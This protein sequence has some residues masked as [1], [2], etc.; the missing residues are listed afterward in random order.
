MIILL[1]KEPQIFG[2]LISV[3]AGEQKEIKSYGSSFDEKTQTYTLK[4]Y[5]NPIIF[6][7]PYR[8]KSLN[9]Y[10]FQALYLI[11]NPS[12]NELEEALSRIE[13][14]V[15]EK[16]FLPFNL[17]KKSQ[18]F[19]LIKP[20]FAQSCSGQRSCY[21]NV[22][23]ISCDN[24]QG[25][26]CAGLPCNNRCP[27]GVGKCICTTQCTQS[28]TKPCYLNAQKTGCVADGCG[29]AT[30]DEE[31][32]CTYYPPA[33]TSTPT[34][35]PPPTATPP[36]ACSLETPT[37][38]VTNIT[39]NSAKLL[40][41]Q[42][43]NASSYYLRY[44]PA[45][46]TAGS[47]VN[48]TGNKEGGTYYLNAANLN[49]CTTYNYQGKVSNP[50]CNPP[51]KESVV[52]TFTTTCP[53]STPTPTFTPTPTP[54]PSLSPPTLKS[55]PDGSSFYLG[56]YVTLEVNPITNYQCGPGQVQYRIPFI[57]PAGVTYLGAWSTST[58]RNTGPY[59]NLGTAYWWAEARFVDSNG[60]V[61][62]TS[63]ES[64]R[65]QFYIISPTSTPP[66]TNTPT[67][68]FTPT[69]TP[70]CDVAQPLSYTA[71][72]VSNTNVDLI[73]WDNATDES[74]F[75]IERR[76]GSSEANLGSW[77]FWTTRGPFTSSDPSQRGWVGN[78]D[79]TDAPDTQ[80]Y[81]WRIRSQ[82]NNP[83]NCYSN[84][85]YSNTICPTPTSTPT[86]TP[87]P[88]PICVCGDVWN[89][90]GCGGCDCPSYQRC[91]Y[92]YCYYT[93]WDG[94]KDGECDFRV[95]CIDDEV[96]QGK[97]W[98]QTKE[99]DIHAQQEIFS[100]LPEGVNFSLRG[101]KDPFGNLGFPGVVS[102]GKEAYF[103][104]GEVSDLGWLA[105]TYFPKSPFDYE[106]FYRTLESPSYLV[107]EDGK[108]SLPEG[109]EDL[110]LA[111]RGNMKTANSWN[112]GARKIVILINGK[113][114]I[115]HSIAGAP[116]ER[117][118]LLVVTSGGIGV[119]KNIERFGGLYLTD[120]YF[121][122]SVENDFQSGEF[123]SVPSNLQ[124]VVNG[125]I[126]A[127]N[128]VFNRDLGIDQNKTTPAEKFIYQPQLL[129]NLHPSV[130]KKSFLWEELIP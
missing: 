14:E 122:S 24:P 54:C 129:I 113:F 67:P 60:T 44:W 2:K 88:T 93:Y 84:W 106:Y 48:V 94:T 79:D 4:L 65:W 103:G 22:T 127:R 3:Y 35:I 128:F 5:L 45:G 52:K 18:G 57:S 29:V 95:S 111:Y 63:S 78:P 115:N 76:T 31:L 32:S 9:F 19:R 66:P 118:S 96:C 100:R 42:T 55:P 34:P 41:Y 25:G 112:V 74:F 92:Q 109:N 130:W 68:T 86:L 108:I 36:P 98:F 49:S 27:N 87:T 70:I 71:T 119:S 125:M 124:L 83:P 26:N 110:I 107:P 117:G 97:A 116:D 91:Q 120:G 33:P 38:D 99:G 23:Y 1:V 85:T 30:C 20:I 56:S 75:R 46:S 69:P 12:T 53:T 6:E 102:Y 104:S 50:A 17:K 59:N 62:V 114:L 21:T 37:I 39:L 47:Y 64:E 82:R 28:F 16:E 72:R 61:K 10:I 43:V 51:E 11:T 90:G 58:T 80:C 40:I 121:Y 89:D 8:D 81:Q 15:W 73:F 101:A 126:Y 105:N 77:Q 7:L 13:K 123:V